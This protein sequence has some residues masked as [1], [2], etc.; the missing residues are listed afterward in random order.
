VEPDPHVTYGALAARRLSAAGKNIGEAAFQAR[1][2]LVQSSE[3]NALL[4]LFQS[5][6]G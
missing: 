5:M 2:D 3:G 6:K 4:A 1:H